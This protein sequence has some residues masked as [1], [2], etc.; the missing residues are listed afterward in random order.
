[1][2]TLIELAIYAAIAAALLFGVHKAWDGFKQSIAAP[3]IQ[4]QIKAD[5][6]KIDAA[7]AAQKVAETDRDT[8]RGNQAACDAA[9]KSSQQ[10]TAEWTAAA[11]RANAA[12]KAS[13]AQAAKDAAVRQP[14]IA[15]LQAKAAAKPQ[16]MACEI[17]RDKAKETLRAALKARGNAK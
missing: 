1:M 7:N 10:A 2:G 16:L 12:A 8:A 13:K 5:Q 14:Y 9:L 15:D 6:P 4:A 11:T 17:E 3:Y